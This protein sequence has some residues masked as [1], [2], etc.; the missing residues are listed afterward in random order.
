MRTANPMHISC[1]YEVG[2]ILTTKNAK[3]P[4]ERWPGTSWK[5]IETMLLGANKAHPVGSTGGAE[6][7]SYTPSGSVGGTALTINQMP[8]HTHDER[9][10]AGYISYSTSTLRKIMDVSKSTNKTTTYRIAADSADVT[11]SGSANTNYNAVTTDN[12]G[13][14]ATHTHS[15]TGTAKTISIM[16]PYTAVYIWER[17]A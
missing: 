12:T 13:G 17:I 4:S 7:M 2:D 15:F 1:P 8:T 6:S 16:P 9:W 14:G 10:P 5:A 11:T 3:L